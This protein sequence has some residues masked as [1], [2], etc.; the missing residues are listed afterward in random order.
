MDFTIQ[1]FFGLMMWVA[2]D[3]MSNAQIEYEYPDE[4]FDSLMM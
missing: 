4:L 1:D 2:T 3:E